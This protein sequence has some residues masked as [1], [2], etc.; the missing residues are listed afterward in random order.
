MSD[1]GRQIGDCRHGNTKESCSKCM[2]AHICKLQD[3]IRK[4]RRQRSDDRCWADDEE[5]YAVLEDGDL[6]DN[7]VGDK[8][9]MLKNC[10]RYLQNRC[11]GGGWPTYAELEAKVKDLETKL[12]KAMRT[13]SHSENR[14]VNTAV[15]GSL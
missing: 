4:H 11:E 10:E 9:A 1:S 13:N 8:A 6:G 7:R 5:L 15:T 2:V 12:E 14:Q 3:A